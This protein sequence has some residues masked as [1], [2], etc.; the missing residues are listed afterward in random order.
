[1]IG[2][3]A[4]FDFFSGEKRHAPVFMQQLGLEWFFRLLSDPRRLWKR[5]LIHN[6]RF[7]YFFTKQLFYRH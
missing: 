6:P 1:M 2:V 7:I 3:G 4:A 5:Y